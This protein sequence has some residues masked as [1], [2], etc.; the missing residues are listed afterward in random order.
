MRQTLLFGGLSNIE[1]N[2]NHKNPDLH[3][4]EFGNVYSYHPDRQTTT[5]NL[6]AIKEELHLA[7]W[8]TGNTVSHSWIRPV[9]KTSVYELKAHVESILLRLNIPAKKIRYKSFENEIFSSALSI[10]SLSGK[11]IG[12]L[13]I[14]QKALCKNFDIQTEVYFAELNW[15]VLMQ[16]HRKTAVRFSEIP[17]F[18]AVR[19]DLALLIDQ[20]VSFAEIERIAYQTDKKLLKDVILFDVYEGKNLPEGKK[21]YAVSFILQDEEKTLNDIQIESIMSKMQKNIEEKLNAKLR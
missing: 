9:E 6:S 15:N 3:L 21:S 4:Y 7:L 10:E 5:D 14:L 12:I 2:R 20:N 17:K 13:G 19:R 8:L 1:F 16:E 18:P 11:A